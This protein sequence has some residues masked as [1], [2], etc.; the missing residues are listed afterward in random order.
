MLRKIL[1]MSLFAVV[2]VSSSLGLTSTSARKSV[3]TNLKSVTRLQQDQRGKLLHPLAPDGFLIGRNAPAMDVRSLVKPVSRTQVQT[4]TAQPFREL[5]SQLLVSNGLLP[6]QIAPG[7]DRRVT[8]VPENMEI[9]WTVAPWTDPTQLQL[10]FPEVEWVEYDGDQNLI[11]HTAAED[12]LIR[13]AKAWQEVSYQTIEVPLT[14]DFLGEGRVS[15]TPG[16]YSTADVLQ[17]GLRVVSASRAAT[18]GGFTTNATLTVTNGNDSGSGSL[19]DRITAA[20]SGDTIQFSGVTT[21]T[22][23]SDELLI[24]KNLT[25]NGG[26]NGVTITRSGATQFRI[27]NISSGTV[28]LTKL[29]ISNGNNP[30]Q[31]GGIQNSGT[32]T[33]T[34]CV[35]TGNTSPQAGGVQNDSV[36]TLNRC[37]I[38]NNTA[39]GAGGGLVSF[40]TSN[41]LTNC[42]ISNNQAASGGGGLSISAGT[43]T[44]T[45]CTVAYNQST[46]GSGGGIS[47]A[48]GLTVVLKN[49]IVVSNTGSSN[50]NINGT[51]DASSSYNLV[52]TSGSGGLVNGT[53]GNQTGVTSPG[54]DVLASNG[55]YTQTIA[56]LAGSPALDKGAAAAGVTTDQRGQ[57]R[58]TNITTIPAASG[59]DDSDIGAFEII[60]SC[61]TLSFSPSSLPGGTVGLSYLQTIS[62]SGG[63]APYTY[64]VTSGSLPPGLTL[65]SDGT[66]SG[67]PTTNGSFS[68][69]VTAT[70]GFGCT[71]NKAYTLVIAACTPGTSFTVN[72]LGDAPDANPG[73]G[74]CQTAGGVCTLRAAIQ[75]NNAVPSC[76]RTISF[77]VMGTINLTSA[78][79][80][81]SAS[82]TLNNSLGE[83]TVNRS[84][85]G[86]YPIFNVASGIAVTI[87]TLVISNGLGVEG[88][89][90]RNAG[91]LTLTNSML[92]GNGTV[93]ARPVTGGGGGIFNTSTGV[94][95]LNR[96]ALVNN[97]ATG[98]VGNGGAGSGGGGG[99]LGGAVYN[100]GGTV[101]IT[102]TT[103][104]GNQAVG[105]AGGNSGGGCCV[106]GGGAGGGNGG[107]G[108]IVIPT[109]TAP[110]SGGFG[111]GGGGGGNGRD[112]AA[113]G[114][115]G[116]GGGG[117][118]GAGFGTSGAGGGFLGGAGAN[119]SS[120]FSRNGAGGGGGGVGGAIY[121]NSGSM[122]LV[123]VTIASNTAMGGAGGTNSS[124][125]AQNGAAGSSRGGGI[126]NEAGTLTLQNSIVAGNTAQQ[127]SFADC[128]SNST[129]IVTNG[130]NLFGS[131]TGCP[132]GGTQDQTVTP[133]NVFTTALS[134]LGY[135]GGGL[136]QT[137]RLLT[138]SP[139]IDKGSAFT[140]VS[141]DQRSRPRPVDVPGVSSASGGNAS[142]IGAY[143]VQNCVGGVTISPTSL[144]L[145]GSNVPYSQTFTGSGGTSPYFFSVSSGA[146]PTGL[147]LSSDGI[148]SG[149]P[150]TDGTYNF[151]I[152]VS[153]NNG[154]FS[155]QAYTLEVSCPTI[156]THPVSQVICDGGSATVSVTTTGTGVTY[157]WRK[158]GVDINGA[159][160]SSYTI[161]V[162]TAADAGS[163]DVVV[164]TAA[165]APIT[166]NPATLSLLGPTVMTSTMPLW[167]GRLNGAQFEVGTNGASASES[168]DKAFDGTFSKSLIRYTANV[169]YIV[170]PIN[171]SPS[172]RVIN[173]FRVYTA[174]DFPDRDPASYELYGTNSPISGNG[175]FAANLF[176]LISSGSLA[177]PSGRN[178]STLDDANSQEISFSNTTPYQTF[179][180]IFPTVKNAGAVLSTQ[181]AEIKFYP[182]NSQPT[183]STTPVS[184]LQGATIA[185]SAIGTAGPGTSQAA[186]TLTIAVSSDGTN[187]GS[188][189]TLN[190]VTI[191]DLVVAANGTVTATIAATCSASNASFTVRVTNN[192]NQSATATLN[193]TVTANT[194]PT[195]SY[196]NDS[197][198]NGS[199]L[200]INPATGPSDDG[201]ISSIVVQ[202]QGTY[203][204]TI[205]VNNTN[206]VVSISNAGPVG[207][208]TITIR[209]TDDCTLTSDATFTL[210]VTSVGTAVSSIIRASSNPACASTS[211]SWTVTFVGS[212]TGV[213]ASN[214]A[215]AGGTG[216]SITNVTGSG[217][218][219]TVTA[220]T[221]TAAAVSLGLNMVNDTGVNPVLTN[222]PF[223]SGQ[224]YTVNG[225]PTT[226]SAGSD[227]TLCLASP[228]A[229]LAANAPS[230]GTGLWSVVTAPAGGSTL[231]NQF[232][233][234]TSPTA[235]FTPNP[236]AVG[237]YTLR[238][239]ISNAPCTASTDDVV[240]TY[241]ASPTPSNA[242]PDQTLCVGTNAT[243]AANNPS[244]G[245]GQWSVV[246]GPSTSSAQFSNTAS[247]SATFTPAGGAGTYTL[248]WTISNSPCA[249]ST[250]DVV[251]TYQAAPTTS[252]AG[253]DQTLCVTN[254]AATLA[255]NA[256][257]TGTGQWSVVTAPPGGST[258]SG[259]FSN[260]NLA[261]ATFTPAPTVTGTYTLR[262]TIS[263]SPCTASTDDVVL[264]YQATPTTSNA[265][266]DQAICA[267][268]SAT[269]AANNPT[270]GTGQWSVVSGPSTSSAQFSN[271][272][273]RTA[274]FTPGGGAG[275][276]TLRWTISNSPCTPS[277]DDVV[278]TVN[279]APSVNPVSPTAICS[280]GTTSIAL[281][282]TPGGASFSWTI[283][284]VT[285][286][287][288][289]QSAG[290]GS[291]IAQ[292]L[293]GNGTV[294]YVVTGTL[295]GCP[296]APVN[297]V[298]TVNPNP[299][300][301]PVSP[302][303]ICSGG[304]TNIALTSTPSGASFSWTIGTVTGSVTGQTAGSGSSIAQTLTGS[305]SVTYV[306]TGTLS[307]CPSAPVNIVQSVTGP[308]SVNPVSPTAICSGG[309]TNIALTS[310]PGGATFSWTIGTVTGSVTGQTAG[311]GSTIAQTLTG[312]GTVTY[313]VTPSLSG[314][315]GTPVNIVQTVNPTPSVNPVSPTAICSGGTTSIALTSTPGGASFSWTIG[316]VTGTVTGQ[317]AGSGSSIAQTLTGN[318]T[319]T[320]VVTGT[321]SGCPSAPVN[322]VQ[323]VN[324]AAT[325]NA[326]PDQTVC[327][328]NPAVTL[329]GV[330]GGGAAT[331]TWSGGAGSF[332]PDA[333]TLNAV[334]TPST[335]EITAGTVTLTLTT[336]D[337]SGPCGAVSDTVTIT[338]VNCTVVQY[339]LMVADTTNNRIQGFDGTNWAVIG[340]GTVGSGPGQFR[341][342]EAVAFDL[343]GRIYVADTGNNR[344]QW[345]T[346]GGTTWADFAT[347][348][349]GTNQVK[350]PQGLTL[351]SEGNLYVSDTGNGRVMRFDD[352]NPGTGVVIASNGTGGGQV[353]S[354]RGLAIDATFRL[355]ITDETNSR[356]L[357]ITNAHTTVATASGTIL[358]T[359]GTGM[360][361][362]QNPQG[363]TIDSNGTLFIADTGNSRILRWVNANPNNASTMALIGSQ[364]GQVNRPEGVTVVT[365]TSGPFA[366]GPMLIVGD[367]SNNRI[368][369]RYIP[370]GQWNLVGSPNNIG[371]GTGQFRSPSKIQ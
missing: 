86:N 106:G 362:V 53:N 249:P 343:T 281:T 63:T 71:G 367:T 277:T 114:R 49:T 344:I 321:L 40:G 291:S 290:S 234:V 153:D 119:S 338:I 347:N 110:Q 44:M 166:S 284:T 58:P 134:P 200:V 135:F 51:L 14:V 17:I 118:Y 201:T 272:A 70:Y 310:T 368:Q 206:G 190:G 317:S 160:N 315:T 164:D 151:T 217:T 120:S 167:G 117:G 329:A 179:M 252:N 162:F 59:G 258:A 220:N 340:V 213:T 230:T 232:S 54:L 335:G 26:T 204:G 339:S 243:L 50:Q 125:V 268:S 43:L 142:D 122:T 6:Q 314:C 131:G 223:T 307:G 235:T 141:V 349:T 19:R 57:T 13:D 32:L 28:S 212:V 331:G 126:Y 55:G 107:A 353:G 172:G 196:N 356:I 264:T 318:G 185:G 61:S 101:S 184:L 108:G 20:A 231:S 22:L 361:K 96:C 175:P 312:S 124:N 311:S 105:G 294:T 8:G 34:E 246:S 336:D 195:L 88:G 76:G 116:G 33:M 169:G 111:G 69:T 16:V 127:A 35:V 288:T 259:Q 250:D 92:I 269:L 93:G 205:S 350:A 198:A 333:N 139:A 208:H 145:I 183:L 137:H 371:S 352:G 334:Y 60:P 100:N 149:T 187:F 276:Y 27:F 261:T 369:G 99:G 216:A 346:D 303:A 304:I 282:S 47:F 176:T 191:N 295:S 305:G 192:Q 89:G 194:A 299:V 30:G 260:V 337:P 189:A 85:G 155:T 364:L 351:D 159:T 102:N 283:G 293:T 327:A 289:G 68:F 224:T 66:L 244:V 31:A 87:N 239:T 46:S 326:G 357:R 143:E 90:I 21:V 253:P 345:S 238:W 359:S 37:T 348:G 138:G 78:L 226:A 42:T 257:S 302:T 11:L 221:G 254:P 199:A 186:N 65:L 215:L 227:Q 193:V 210:T 67:V 332:S 84:S 64:A 203:T 323:S 10:E 24:D 266:P 225:V 36:I 262:W 156:T 300:V 286:S 173:R 325:T 222:L 73:D 278:V 263:N 330:I 41:T 178:T 170:S 74:V 18:G 251:L 12:I 121:Q 29:T 265:G 165:C 309:T 324:P 229:T 256:A 228:T 182:E 95:T 91:S 267:G 273:S 136:T 219:W 148:L 316:T 147:A 233:V 15:I 77:S 255:A 177:L 197:V 280:G 171:C 2:I 112:G 297:I 174:N 75:E 365:F 154:C 270:V 207:T 25:I 3:D 287:V 98:Q 275:V 180:L 292:T 354:P 274:T 115:Y 94:L 52:G 80:D 62:A 366:G 279:S 109:S 9:E 237:S 181:V 163:Y 202:D 296:S 341:L 5:Q 342:P 161:P 132:T 245:T 370:T 48:N 123:N 104:S 319:V 129:A 23:T 128:D 301:N 81:L 157:Q 4:V 285:G 144:P 298:Q 130:Y 313:V 83:I 113:G 363:I 211:V 358:A 82:V 103:F 38:A 72:D 247:Q 271:T 355:F 7:L 39:T 140:G 218:T 146:L 214:F 209:A 306:V 320:Y 308:P 97:T 158:G 240:I 45:N 1:G 168:P 152:L 79:P 56:L 150:T 248:R 360:N 242:G 133:A 236:G 188:S 328:D 322:I 241:Q